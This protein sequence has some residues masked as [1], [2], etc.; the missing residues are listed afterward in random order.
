M[1]KL[2]VA[3]GLL[4]FVMIVLLGAA[5]VYLLHEE[6][7]L[8]VRLSAPDEVTVGEAF[9]LTLITR[10]LHQEA[11]VLDSV[12]IEETF[13]E[14]FEVVSVDPTPTEEQTIFWYRSWS[15]GHSVQPG[16]TMEVTFRLNPLKP[17][18]YVG[19]VDVCNANQDFTTVIP[20][21]DVMAE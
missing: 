16:E 14:G 12:D 17:G 9:D 6:P 2:M 18:H 3:I 20:N 10:N 1:K 5:V 4:G 11:I 7:T 21:I 19:D 13:L 8:D 15:F